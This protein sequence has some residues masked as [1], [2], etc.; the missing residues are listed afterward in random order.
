M[1]FFNSVLYPIA[2]HQL[3]EQEVRR[4]VTY[5][6]IPSLK[7]HDDTEKLLQQVILDRRHDGDKISL[8]QIYELLTKLKDQNTITKFER[9]ETMRVLQRY[10]EDHFPT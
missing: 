9:D 8:Q 3:I 4:V 6:T 5:L 1:G 2:E 10:F 7:G